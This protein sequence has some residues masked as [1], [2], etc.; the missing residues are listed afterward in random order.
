VASPVTVV[1]TVT[2]P[3]SPKFAAADDATSDR[4]TLKGRLPTQPVSVEAPAQSLTAVAGSV[5]TARVPANWTQEAFEV[6][7]GGYLQSL[8]RDP[9]HPNDSVGVDTVNGETTSPGRKGRGGPGSYGEDRGIRRARVHTDGSRRPRRLPL[10]LNVSGDR[11]VDYMLNECSTGIAVL[12]STSPSRWLAVK[13][14]FAKIAQSVESTCAADAPPEQYDAPVASG[15]SGDR[16]CI[17]FGLQ[18]AAQAYFEANG[19]GPTNNVDN[20][21]ADH[22]GVAC[23]WLPGGG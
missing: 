11:R 22:D 19:G 3:A 4:R 2:A 7:K 9:A 6:D 16:D 5:F 13:A 23:E 15:G 10:G 1:K 8:W 20:L 17:S 12:G 18:P 21:D 14:T